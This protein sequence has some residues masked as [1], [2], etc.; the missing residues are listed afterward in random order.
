MI[1]EA[2]VVVEKSRGESLIL[3]LDA[4]ASPRLQSCRQLTGRPSNRGDK[5]KVLSFR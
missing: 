2:G 3:P 5:N 4:Y 1:V